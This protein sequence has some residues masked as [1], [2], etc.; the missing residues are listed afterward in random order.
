MKKIIASLLTFVLLISNTALAFSDTYKQTSSEV[1]NDCITSLKQNVISPTVSS[2][3]G[4]WM[5]LALA[6]GDNEDNTE[7][8][9]IYYENLC[10]YLKEN[11]G[12]LHDKK[13]TEYSRV[14]IALS[15]IG[16]RADNVCDYNLLYYLADYEKVISQGLNGPIFALIALDCKN[17]DIPVCENVNICATREMYVD[18][19]LN[20]QLENGGFALNKTSNADIDI[21][22]MAVVSLSNYSGSEKVNAAIN[23]ALSYLSAS[24]LEN[25]GFATSYSENCES[26][27]QVLCMLST[28]NISIDDPRFV[29]NSN[30]VLDALM[31]YKLE[32]G[33]FCHT[34]GA[35]LNIMATEQ[36]AYSLAAYIRYTNGNTSLYDM[37]DVTL[38]DNQD[39]LSAD[40]N[41]HPDIKPSYIIYPNKT[42]ADICDNKYKNEITALA[43][44]AIIN[45]KS[46]DCYEPLCE[47]TRGEFATLIV[48][49][50]NLPL[51]KEKIFTDVTENDWYFA[52]VSTAYKYGIISGISDNEFDPNGNVTR[53]QAATITA[54]CASLCGC[55]ITNENINYTLSAFDDYKS[56]SDWAKSS[57]AF[58]LKKNIINSELFEIN[59]KENIKRDEIAYMLYT[60]L[61]IS[62]LL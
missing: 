32:N 51:S 25:G 34:K 60:L 29:K 53:E 62:N 20:A 56:V 1:L 6:R 52:A 31:S 55:D 28:L 50:L 58:C 14:I 16:K 40:L 36:A 10:T 41:Q 33:G 4:E 48:N 17:Y 18:Y 57:V 39:D 26:C 12:I 9:N 59:P 37:S 43:S 3:G 45:G 22:A 5:I 15:A 21:T 54:R 13:Y 27:A 11:N 47:M 44:R 2:V 42:F 61:D 7:L 30:T 24:Q 46:E 38:N 35:K 8:F 19:I 23:N 49:T